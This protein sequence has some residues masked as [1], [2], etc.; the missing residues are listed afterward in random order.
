MKTAITAAIRRHTTAGLREALKQLRS[1]LAV[2]K[3]HRTGVR[4]ARQYTNNIKLHLGSGPNYKSNWVNVDLFHNDADLALDLREPLP[5]QTASVTNIYSEHVFEHFTFPDEAN[6]LLSECLRVLTPDGT[7]DLGVPDTEYAIRNYYVDRNPELLAYARAHWHREP[8]C[9][10]PLHQLNYHFRQGAEH[11]YA[12][13]YETLNS[14]LAKAGFVRITRRE[15]DP[16]LDDPRRREGTL[17][18][19]AHKQPGQS[20][21][22]G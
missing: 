4:R 1:E 21:T 6:R 22:V 13:D 19:R 12:W 10:L 2:Q 14:V 16:A 11:K 17:Y 9:D 8:W 7:F 3:R 20:P 5:F 18:V 15:F